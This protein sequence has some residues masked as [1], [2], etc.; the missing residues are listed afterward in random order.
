MEEG[1]R[2]HVSKSTVD[3]GFKQVCPFISTSCLETIFAAEMLSCCFVTSS[4][5]ILH[6]LL[7][8]IDISL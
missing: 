5:L 6:T 1:F 7:Y 2:Y 4:G 3:R 8:A